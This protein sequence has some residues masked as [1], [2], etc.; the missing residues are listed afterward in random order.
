MAAQRNQPNPFVRHSAL[1]RA[2]I[3]VVM[4]LAYTYY[5]HQ[6]RAYYRSLYHYTKPST[7][8]SA[9]AVGAMG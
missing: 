6:R 7:T 2:L 1:T 4:L 3:A 9:V 8:R 5:E